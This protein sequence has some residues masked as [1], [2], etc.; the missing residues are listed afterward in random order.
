MM[1]KCVLSTIC[2]LLLF[3]CQA[4]SQQITGQ[5][6]EEN[7]QTELGFVNVALY[8]G[9]DNAKLVKGTTSDLDGYF[10]ID[11]VAFGNYMLELSYVGY[12]SVRF[13][14]VL[15]E[16]K[17][18][19][20]L[21]KIKMEEDSQLL[22]GVVV[23]GQRSQMRFDVDKKVFD[24]S[25]SIISEGASASD[26]LS[27]IPSVTVD[28]E[29]NISLRNNENVTIWINGRPSGLTEDTRAQI[30]EQLPA[31]GIE[32]VEIITNPS[33]RFSAE[34]AA[35]IIN[36]VMKKEKKTGYYGGVT[37]NA[38]TQGGYGVSANINVN[39]NKIETYASAGWKARRFSMEQ[40]IE[41]ETFDTQAAN[42]LNQSIKGDMKGDSFFARAGLT[43]HATKKDQFSLSGSTNVGTRA[44]DKSVK[45]IAGMGNNLR[46]TNEDNPMTS[47][48]L[49]MDYLHTFDKGSNL[50]IAASYDHTNRSKDAIYTQ[51][52]GTLEPVGIPS[53]QIQDAPGG[54]KEWDMQLD[55]TKAFSEFLRLEAGYKGNIRTFQS[56]M[57]SWQGGDRVD[58]A[59][60]PSL[61]NDF[62]Q[63]MQIHAMYLSFAGKWDKLSYQAGVRS[64]YTDQTTYSRG[65]NESATTRNQKDYIR[66]FPSAFLSYALT[67]S[68]E[69]QLNYTSRINRPH[70]RQ[71]NPFLQI[72][73]SSNISFGNPELEPEYTSA[74]E[75]NYIKNWEKHTLSA[76]VYYRM[77][78]NLRQRISYL[79]GNTVY[80]TYDNVTQSRRAG[81]ELVGKNRLFDW[82]DLTSTVNLYYYK[83]DGY[84]YAREGIAPITLKG[85]EDF[86]WDARLIANAMLPWGMS[87]QLSGNY[88]SATYSPQSKMHDRYWFDAGLKKS[89]LDRKLN[90]SISCRDILNSRLWKTT[91]YGQ[92]FTQYSES[93]WGGRQGAIT[94]SYSFG[95]SRSKSRKQGNRPEQGGDMDSDMMDF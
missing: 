7:G 40:E 26:A 13:P 20:A 55:Y 62:S 57:I 68:Q 49:S 43:W 56:D 6:T 31:D 73:D 75:M 89:F 16:K 77:T 83:V 34:G 61:T 87:L 23:R 15:S 27:N 19:I 88:N 28:H 41:R 76:S 4:Y 53:I 38:D 95:N 52:D 85:Q 58:S 18:D 67:E 70:G 32:S 51:Y 12:K 60:E 82:L 71:L 35:G 80:T 17:K 72:S 21:G 64:E 10:K 46:L 74:L 29:G 92:N 65:W 93:R 14:V 86:S 37:A 59:I 79:Q 11:G 2:G 22:D 9:Q 78:D 91:T 47:Y 25:Q 90:V 84:T 33:A 48:S 45:T 63:D 44:F 3:V 42:S 94:I 24:V 81:M 30:L 50:K 54:H 36:I 5:T 69:L 1:K 66:F 39:Y 8:Q